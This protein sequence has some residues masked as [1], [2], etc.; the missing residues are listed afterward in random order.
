[1]TNTETASL[2]NHRSKL[3]KRAN[4]YSDKE[5]EILIKEISVNSII[6]VDEVDTINYLDDINKG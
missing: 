2:L 6:S 5:A 1:M 3:T 4:Y